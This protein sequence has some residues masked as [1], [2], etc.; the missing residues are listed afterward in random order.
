MTI[1]VGGAFP[2]GRL[3]KNLARIAIQ[4]DDFEGVF[5]ISADAV[6]M[7]EI[8]AVQLVL[9]CLRSGNLSPFNSSRQKD[10]VA[11]NDRR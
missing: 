2:R 7:N 5:L 1:V 9:H 11:P 4:A 8:F 10:S 6:R 3:P